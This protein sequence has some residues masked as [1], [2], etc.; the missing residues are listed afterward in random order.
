M[1]ER[2]LYRR[3]SFYERDFFSGPWIMMAALCKPFFLFKTNQEYS[4]HISQNVWPDNHYFS[5]DSHEGCLLILHGTS[6][7]HQLSLS[8]AQLALDVAAEKLSPSFPE[9]LQTE[10]QVIGR[11]AT[12][13][14]PLMRSSFSDIVS[15][16]AP[17]VDLLEAS[18]IQEERYVSSASYIQGDPEAGLADQMDMWQLP[19]MAPPPASTS[20]V[21]IKL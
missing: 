4:R 15:D 10:M 9:S 21:G 14:D 19:P 1:T 2:N 5:D 11:M 17:L 12:Q 13:F 6:P 16:L 8:P 3:M 7:I 18:S 20:I